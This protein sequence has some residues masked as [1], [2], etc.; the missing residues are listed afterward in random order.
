MRGKSKTFIRSIVADITFRNVWM[1][2]VQA[3]RIL[4]ERHEAQQA[5]GWDIP[6]CFF[7]PWMEEQ[8][9]RAD[10]FI[11]FRATYTR[12]Q[13]HARRTWNVFDQ[14]SNEWM[15]NSRYHTS[16]T[17]Q[18]KYFN[19]IRET[20]I[21]QSRVF[22]LCCFCFFL[23]SILRENL[24]GIIALMDDS[25]A[26]SIALCAVLILDANQFLNVM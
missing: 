20:H 7:S 10:G 21:F 12:T 14:Y 16:Y 1:K 19:F 23:Y 2:L 24:P 5:V 9:V 26:I 25:S 18:G 3:G 11:G 22:F 4:P 13:T 17:C 6:K 15:S 8:F